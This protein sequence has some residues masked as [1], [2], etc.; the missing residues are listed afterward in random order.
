MMLP[1][2]DPVATIIVC[3]D[4]PPTL[5]LLCDHL[6]ADRFRPLGAP[7]AGDALRLCHY[8]EP[9]PSSD[10]FTARSS[11]TRLGVRPTSSPVGCAGSV[12]S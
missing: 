2:V 4:D 3:E 12:R 6:E 11:G 7:S 9:E 10:L 5:D 1:K 8:N